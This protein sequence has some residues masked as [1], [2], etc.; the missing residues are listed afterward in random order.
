MFSLDAMAE[1]SNS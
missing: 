1:H